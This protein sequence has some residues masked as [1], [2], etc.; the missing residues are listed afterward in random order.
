MSSWNIRLEEDLEDQEGLGLPLAALT[1]VAERSLEKPGS[2]LHK[3]RAVRERA[4]LAP[5]SSW[6]GESRDELEEWDWLEVVR[7]DEVRSP[8]CQ[9]QIFPG[10]E[11]CPV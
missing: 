7:I 11:E 6:L 5:A 2:Q 8:C 10:W 9:V 4:R 3:Y 1:L